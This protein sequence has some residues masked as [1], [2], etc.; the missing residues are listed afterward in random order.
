MQ[1]DSTLRL[2]ALTQACLLGSLFAASEHTW[3]TTS[4]TG[5]PT[6]NWNDTA[7]WSPAS[8]PNAT[9]ANVTIGFVNAG[10]PN[11]LLDGAY[12]VND[13]TLSA[14]GG[15][16]LTLQS[17]NTAGN[18]SL[19]VAGT[20]KKNLGSSI[21]GFQDFNTGRNF[22]LTANTLDFT[23]T[24]GGSFFFGRSDG[25]RF[26]NSVSIANINMGSADASTAAIRFNVTNNYNI[27]LVT[28]SG[29]NT[30]TVSLI[31]NAST[32]AGYAR[33]ATVKGITQSSGT[34]AT[35]EGSFRASASG[36]NAATLQIDTDAATSFTAST[37]LTNGTGGTLALRKTGTGTQI[38]TGTHTFTGG[39][40]VE[41]GTLVISGG[42][43][44]TG[45]LSVSTNATFV[46]AS[47]LSVAN[48]SLQSGAILGFDLNTTSS[49]AIG[50]DL[51]QSGGGAST[52]VIDFRNTGVLDQAYA[53]LISISA[54]AINDFSGATLSY[55]NFGGGS[56]TDSL[57]FNQLQNGFTISAVPEPSTYAILGG[58]GALI[59]AVS[60]RRRR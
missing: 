54:S 5:G 57:T 50:G 35:I 21:V 58:L 44:A 53:G 46:A 49:L 48:V 42:L 31:N 32:A 51:T 11:V 38:L 45:N 27:G 52:F 24:G 29:T 14:N 37:V 41:A 43:A 12:N 22:S 39:T 9:T 60:L 25:G 28:F 47:S 17:I 34:A 36:T 56:L 40:S 20:I 13:L 33:T 6:L 18:Y 19:T 55:V 10:S 2:L 16:T 59:A 26:I 15:N 30:K 1:S 23:T 4:A 7:N 8:V 3:T